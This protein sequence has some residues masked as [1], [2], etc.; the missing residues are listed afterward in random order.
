MDLLA[1]DY[2]YKFVVDGEDKVDAKKVRSTAGACHKGALFTFDVFILVCPSISY[3]CVV[4][5][6]WQVQ[7]ILSH[8]L[9]TTSKNFIYLMKL[10]A[11]ACIRPNVKENTILDIV[12]ISIT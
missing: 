2:S 11:V 8:M 6:V 12:V 1:G 4:F 7:G 3:C 10:T 5:I 9:K